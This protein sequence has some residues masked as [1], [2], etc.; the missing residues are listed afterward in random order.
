MNTRTSWGA[1][2]LFAA[3]V[4]SP[5]AA[6]AQ[7]PAPAP[8]P[9]GSE[10]ERRKLEEEIKREM[11]RSTVPR[12]RPGVSPEAAPG[13]TPSA[14]SST[15]ARLALLPDLS[16]I[17]SVSLR[18]DDATEK[19]SFAFEE[20]EIGLQAVVDPYLRADVFLAF[21]EE[22][23]EIEEAFVTTLSL[24][25]GL[26][27]RA[28]KLF[29]PFGRFNQMHPHVWE[30]VEAP[31]AQRLLS[32]ESLGGAGV[33]VGWLAPVPWFA[34]LHLAA[35]STAPSE[36]DEARLTGVARLAQYFPLGTAAT[37]GLGLSA[38]R[39]DEGPS[40]FRDLAGADLHLRF[41]PLASRSYLNLSGEVYARRFLDVEGV[42]EDFENGWWV[43]AFGRIGAH[44]GAGVRWEQ[45]P[46]EEL[47]GH[48]KRLSGLLAW[49][50]SEFQR[51]RLEVSR[52]RLPD[53]TGGVT[54]LLHLEFG[55]GAHGAHPF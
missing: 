10:E 7:E 22:G 30:F 32:E 51:I 23:A 17:G 40:Q 37:L 15:L 28:G 36:E 53:D 6:V 43:Q 44:F 14:A 34:E 21:S 18:W 1:A 13:T 45:A 11:G 20:L 16:A 9:D 54:A 2:A 55:I 42:S 38:A 4:V 41:R 39:R 49:M 3:L 47:D 31:L 50:P 8:A 24:P 5:S 25:A 27:V 33:D 26:Q 29:S 46:A 35:Q 19:A 12:E 52:D 48:E